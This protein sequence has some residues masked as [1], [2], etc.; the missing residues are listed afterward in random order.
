MAMRT[1][2]R[3]P[4][5][6]T[7][8]GTRPRATNGVTGRDL[9]SAKRSAPMALVGV[10]AVVLGAMLFLAL[11]TS[12]DRR[13]SVLAVVRPVAAGEVITA[14]DLREVR[15]SSSD[16]VATMA[17]SQRASVVGKTA[18]VGLVPGALL[19]PAQ[20]GAAS[21]L[22]AGQAVVGVAIKPGQAPASLRAG[23][24]VEVVDT[25]RANSGDQPRP[26][27]LSTSAVVSSVGRSD[28]SPNGT[29]VV[30]L[31]LPA[32]EAPAVAAA[33]L[34]GRLSLVVLPVAP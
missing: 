8:N 33:A 4:A 15:V 28:T 20:L 24:R 7:P 17:A 5:S 26:V 16:G 19:A 31:T 18:A 14:A 32:A 21:T 10:A 23:T 9:T 3:P 25:V 22:A 12:V 29:T 11:Y 13:R 30:S 27:V 1:S 34:D 2:P 6:P